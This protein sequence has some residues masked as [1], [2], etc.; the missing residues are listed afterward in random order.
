MTTPIAVT[1]G[2]LTG[3]VGSCAIN[4]TDVNVNS[5]TIET[6]ATN[7]CTGQVIAD[8]TYFNWIAG[9]ASGSIFLLILF[10]AFFTKMIIDSQ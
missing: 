6:I 3:N 7:S 10:F 4:S 9:I 1:S 8:H 2:N 5:F